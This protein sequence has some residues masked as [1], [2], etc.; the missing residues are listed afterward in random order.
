V[1]T[2]RISIEAIHHGL[3]DRKRRMTDSGVAALVE[4]ITNLGL[5]TPILVRELEPGAYKLLAGRHRLEACR[6]LGWTD[7]PAVVQASTGDAELDQINDELAEIDE[8][9][10]RSELGAVEQALHLRDRKRLYVAKLARQRV[11]EAEAQAAKE[12]AETGKVS[13]K[14]RVLAKYRKAVAVRQVSADELPS[15][16]KVRG[17][18]ADTAAKAGVSERTQR[19]LVHRGDVLAE[20]AQKAGVNVQALSGAALDQASE[21]D[22][23]AELAKR[24]PDAAVKL[25]KRVAT[26][27]P[28]RKLAKPS[29]ALAEVKQELVA[30]ARARNRTGTAEELE[31]NDL[32][33]L[34][35]KASHAIRAFQRLCER[36]NRGELAEL[37]NK[38]ANEWLSR[39]DSLRSGTAVTTKKHLPVQPGKSAAEVAQREQAKKDQAKNAKKSVRR[40]QPKSKPL[41]SEAA[42]H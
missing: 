1:K 20:I 14:T 6:K 27:E 11:T 9:L 10:M 38:A 30:E 24:K 29:K 18:T 23:L 15:T 17:F 12:K 40:L 13:E 25:V 36:W 31:N 34:A 21:I 37:A 2:Q 39:A 8:N 28:A 7:I 41:D 4:S 42:N 3:A 32:V 33:R 5:Q 19:Q 16:K 26:E 22:K 35:H